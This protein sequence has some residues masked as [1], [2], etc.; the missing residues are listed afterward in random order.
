MVLKNYTCK[1]VD[2]YSG[3]SEHICKIPYLFFQVNKTTYTYMLN[4]SEESIVQ[5]VPQRNMYYKY[6]VEVSYTNT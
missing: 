2:Y 6:K 3:I 4:R 5:F 1:W